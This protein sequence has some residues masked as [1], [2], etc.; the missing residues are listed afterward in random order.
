MAEEA[1]KINN[2]VAELPSHNN[3]NIDNNDNDNTLSTEQTTESEQTQY[4]GNV[5][6][7]F[8]SPI[9]LAGK[10]VTPIS[11]GNFP[12]TSLD[13]RNKP[14]PLS[15]IDNLRHLLK[16]YGILVR[17]DVIGKSIEIMIPGLAGC[18]DNA[19]AAAWAT[20]ISLVKLNK[21][22][23][24]HIADYLI[25]VA[26]E[27]LYNPVADWI[28]TKPW[29]GIDRLE[30]LA[31]TLTVTE[32]FPEPLRDILVR[33]WLI[34][35]VAAALMP[36]GFGTRGVLVL[37]GPQSIG[38]TR[39]IMSL[40]PN[41]T[42]QEQVVKIDHHLDASDKDSKLTALRHWIVEIGELDSSFRK[43]VAR[44][45]GFITGTKD[46]IR[47]PYG[48]ADS[49]Y[50]RRTVFCAT[51]NKSDFLVDDTGNTRWWTIPVTAIDY[52][53][54]IDMQQV[55]A[56]VHTYYAGG[57]NWWL[58]K[59][60]E[61]QLEQYNKDHQATSVIRD[62]LESALDFSQ[63]ATWKTAPVLSAT[64]ILQVLDIQNP[65]N[66]QAKECAAVM[67]EHLGEPTKSNGTRGWRVKFPDAK[68]AIT[69]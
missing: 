51:V 10:A 48:R 6:A 61:A 50:S 15:T 54:N 40:V 58:T 23:P 11:P 66:T 33:R 12:D 59:D 49:E 31:Q 35:A 22:P 34:S 44:L 57:E 13:A 24:G 65:T 42:L 21:I 20:I 47:V 43:D 39:W 19:D 1:N 53:H 46:K 27:N 26:N 29:D 52:T 17:Y 8:Q 38:K 7:L 14:I 18:P 25:A 37:Q 63:K 5:K 60:E 32:E 56:Q 69:I 64:K 3:D 9:M 2:L 16:H 30:A 45:K 62:M 67:R 28:L 68:G 36:S 41:Q 55:F 4:N